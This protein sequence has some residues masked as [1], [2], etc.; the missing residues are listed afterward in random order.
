MKLGLELGKPFIGSLGATGAMR[1]KTLEKMPD[2]PP[3]LLIVDNPR[4]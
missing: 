2:V 4:K 3:P 1:A